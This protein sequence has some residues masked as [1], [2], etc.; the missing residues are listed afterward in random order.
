VLVSTADTAVAH[1]QT[2]QPGEPIPLTL[3]PA[4]PP[5][6]ALA[7]R[8][9]PE[10]QDKVP[11]NAAV[12]YYRTEAMLAEN[13]DLLQSVRAGPWSVRA[14]MPI[15]ELPLDDV[16][17]RLRTVRH[18]LRELDEAARRR[19]CD[20]QLANRPEGIGLLLPDVQGF[21]AFAGVLAVRARYQMARGNYPEAVASLRTGYALGRA[22][23]RGPT[24]IQ[25]LVGA[26]IVQVM[27]RQLEDLVQQP[28]AP[29]LYW[30]L[31]VLPR[32]FLNLQPA[33]DDEA[34]MLERSL[35]FAKRLEQGPMSPAEVEGAQKEWNATLE[36]FGLRRPDVPETLGLLGAQLGTLI[37]AK[38]ALVAQ[39]FTE[40]QL[41]AMPA[42]QVEGVYAL[43]EYRRTWD[44]YT[45]WFSVPSFWLQPGSKKARGDHE[46]AM[47]RLDRLYFRTLLGGVSGYERVFQAMGRV[48]RRFAALRCVE[49]L[50]LYAAGHE[51]KLPAKLS[52]ITEVP[53]PA[54]P[55][56]GKSF[57]Y[58]VKGDK[59]HLTSP[60]LP[61]GNENPNSKTN[62]EISLRR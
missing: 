23:D 43:R 10:P 34:T 62:Y 40:A 46:V 14:E 22:M 21:R 30:S 60:E 29:D 18:L 26:A 4:L 54:D 20:W 12:L 11:G 24:F 33:I 15:Q 52:D 53:V 35:P 25:V 57:A 5:A 55:V 36:K 28:G 7:Y 8:L 19:D 1:T 42:F 38:H 2:Q 9:F 3:T 61:G 47:I 32:P 44:E 37:E 48:D 45:K 6:P 16:Y 39:G 13:G 49:A 56:T 50:R 17:A 41:E 27:N 59:V 51:G 58:V 31:A